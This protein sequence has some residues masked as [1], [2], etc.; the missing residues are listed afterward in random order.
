MMSSTDGR[1]PRPSFC[2]Q[3]TAGVSTSVRI[4][5]NARGMRIARARYRIAITATRIAA[6]RT[7]EL[8]CETAGL[9][10]AEVALRSPRAG[11]G[12]DYDAEKRS[13]YIVRDNALRVC[14]TL[15]IVQSIF[16]IQRSEQY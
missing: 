11:L 5:A 8:R 6:V 7:P 15:L 2:S 12:M 1:R 9:I 14:S 4:M 3:P 13:I 16:R 10:M